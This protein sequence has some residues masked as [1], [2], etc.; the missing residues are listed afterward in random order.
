M[1]HGSEGSDVEKRFQSK[2]AL[3]TGGTSGMGEAT[4][5]RLAAEGAKVVCVG[6]NSE[7][8]QAV[9]DRIKRSG[10]EALFVAADV[11]QRSLVE[12]AVKKCVETFGG[13]DVLFNNAGNV[14]PLKEIAEMTEEEWDE[15]LDVNLKSMFLF[16]KYALPYLRKSKGTIV[17][18]SSELG[19]IGAPKYTA[20]CASKGG[21]VLFTR[22]LALECAPWQVRVNCV[23]PGFTATRMSEW[24]LSHA[25]DK[26]AARKSA[27]E[28]VP[29]GRMATPDEIANAVAFLAS[30]EAKYI[31][32]AILS[33]DGGTT[34]K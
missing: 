5:I 10:G 2:V 29:L 16:S 17:N 3:V 1:V 33:I 20:Y 13:I 30:D 31:T 23:S 26:E 9:V 21:V 12:S 14:G 25:P 28:N 15:V 22:A 19:L 6:R 11:G 24:E 18:T 7:R 27:I 8:G 34:I 4:A 32:G